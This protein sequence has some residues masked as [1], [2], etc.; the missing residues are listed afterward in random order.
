MLYKVPHL[1]VVWMFSYCDVQKK[2]VVSH[3][4]TIF[5]PK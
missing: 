1:D 2:D 3:I 4:E 5:F